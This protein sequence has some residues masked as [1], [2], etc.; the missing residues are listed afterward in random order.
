MSYLREYLKEFFTFRHTVNSSGASAAARMGW[1]ADTDRL[2]DTDTT[3]AGSGGSG[4]R[5]LDPSLALLQAKNRRAGFTGL[6]ADIEPPRRNELL[7]STFKSKADMP[8][9]RPPYDRRVV[10]IIILYYYDA[11]LSK[12]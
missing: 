2:I 7:R 8:V 1:D 9:W 10:N 11:A 5:K 6:A 3:T 12:K 4:G